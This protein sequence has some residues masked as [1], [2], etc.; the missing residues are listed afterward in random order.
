MFK[1]SDAQANI[2]RTAGEQL[3]FVVTIVDT[4]EMALNAFTE[5]KPELVVVD[6]RHFEPPP[7]PPQQSA[8]NNNG[9]SETTH[10]AIHLGNGADEAGT[11]SFDPIEL[12]R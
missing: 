12:A 11:P 2:L 4:A 8:S 5:I 6:G 9:S 7:P 10:K 3:G 1:K